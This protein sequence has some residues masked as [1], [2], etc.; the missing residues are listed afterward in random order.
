MKS[1][2]TGSVKAI[3]MA[4]IDFV[5]VVSSHP[6]E[7]SE[8]PVLAAATVVGGPA[9]RG[10]IT[11]TRLG[12]EVTLMATRGSD[13]FGDLLDS[14]VQEEGVDCLWYVSQTPSQHS[15]VLVT[16]TTGTR[17][18][19]WLPQPKGDQRQLEEVAGLVKPGD[20]VLLDCTDESLTRTA[21]EASSQ[22]G[23]V[24]VM[25][26][27]SYRPWS[28]PILGRVDHVVAPE[29]FFLSRNSG[30]DPIRAALEAYANWGN[31]SV[32]ITQGA[33]GYAFVD[34]NGLHVEPALAIETVDS[35]GAGDTYHGAFAA[36]LSLGRSVPAAYEI[37]AWAA[38]EKCRALGNGTIPDRDALEASGL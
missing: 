25:D 37:A 11:A 22:V 12:A 7:D 38:G 6:E 2:V 3:G 36:A 13:M 8:N 16:S 34:T 24:T 9:G 26:T 21:V 18:T 28:E 10:A 27:G 31:S 29:K 23:A 20:V 5:R 17:T 1:T 14:A 19:V 33:K 30:A 35:C 32:G 15:F 4:T